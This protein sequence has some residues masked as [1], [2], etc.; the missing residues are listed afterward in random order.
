MLCMTIMVST[1]TM[2]PTSR[3]QRQRPLPIHRGPR[4]RTLISTYRQYLTLIR[5]STTIKITKP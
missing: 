3:P 1:T 5:S 4:S 2:A